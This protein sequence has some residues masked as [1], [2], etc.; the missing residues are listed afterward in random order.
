[1]KVLPQH[2]KGKSQPPGIRV[3]QDLH[4][5]SLYNPIKLVQL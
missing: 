1:M 2:R 4:S 5:H 3:T